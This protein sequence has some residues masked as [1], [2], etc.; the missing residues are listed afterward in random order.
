MLQV[1]LLE[2]IL[3]NFLSFNNAIFALFGIVSLWCLF[4]ISDLWNNAD[5][6]DTLANQKVCGVINP[7]VQYYA[8]EDT[9]FVQVNSTIRGKNYNWYIPLENRKIRDMIADKETM[10]TCKKLINITVA[11]TNDDKVIIDNSNK[12]GG[13]IGILVFCCIFSG[14]F[15]VIRD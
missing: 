3:K 12:F 2:N 8:T 7:T 10:R 13:S 1:L 11:L 14:L 4:N 5:K 6:F 9:S 15:W